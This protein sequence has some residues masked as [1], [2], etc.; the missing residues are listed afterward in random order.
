MCSRYSFTSPPEAVRRLFRT[1]NSLE[2]PP[3]P[4]IAPTEPVII[5]RASHAGQREMAL[6][7]WG[8][9][10]PWV[11]DVRDFATV[12]NARAET[13]TEKPSFRGAIR[14]RR[15]LVPADG[16]YEW[17]GPPRAKTPHLIR[18]AGD[19]SLMALAGLW[20]HWVGADGSELETMAIVTTA[21]NS[22]CSAIHDRMP[23]VLQPTDFDRWLD[24]TPGSAEP[25]ADLLHPPPPGRLVHAV[26]TALQ[27][28]RKDPPGLFPFD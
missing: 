4:N 5:V 13:I 1:R 28:P 25:I 11:K 26:A 19:E 20:E 8:L 27:R 3:R 21:S 24:V 7:R 17:T 16:Y 15:C 6:V 10:P 22:D 14:H 2:F 23:L 18:P 12:L 9:I